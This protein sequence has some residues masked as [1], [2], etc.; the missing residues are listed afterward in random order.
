MLNNNRVIFGE[1]YFTI[2]AFKK[3]FYSYTAP[4]STALDFISIPHFIMLMQLLLNYRI[5]VVE[6]V[7]LHNLSLPVP[8]LYNLSALVVAYIAVALSSNHKPLFGPQ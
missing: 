4:G 3:T 1:I 7:N 8:G 6:Y 2:V 5:D